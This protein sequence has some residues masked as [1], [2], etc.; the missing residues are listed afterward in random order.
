MVYQRSSL[1]KSSTKSSIDQNAFVWGLERQ[2]EWPSLPRPLSFA[3][4]LLHKIRSVIFRRVS[5]PD[6][7][8]VVGAAPNI[9]SSAIQCNC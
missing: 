7:Y 4:A 6:A 8:V 2:G 9:I 3:C 1:A 5:P